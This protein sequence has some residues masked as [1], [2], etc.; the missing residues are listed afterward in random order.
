MMG[1]GTVALIFAILSLRA[2]GCSLAFGIGGSSWLL[3]T[4]ATYIPSLTGLLY[5]VAFN[6]SGHPKTP[7][8]PET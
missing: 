2:D 1:W 6:T 5:W 4:I 7:V 8:N 3:L